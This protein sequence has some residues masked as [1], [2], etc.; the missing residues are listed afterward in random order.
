MASKSVS[1]MTHFSRIDRTAAA[2]ATLF[3][4]ILAERVDEHAVHPAA[5]LT[6]FN[7]SLVS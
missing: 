4:N 3:G 5:C 1:I 2:K 7:A 6:F